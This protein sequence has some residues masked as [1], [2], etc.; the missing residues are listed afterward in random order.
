M[1]EQR[2]L[3]PRVPGSSPG[4][5]IFF[6]AMHKR[7]KFFP[8]VI[9]FLLLSVHSSLLSQIR[10]KTKLLYFIPS[11][12]TFREIYGPGLMG[13]G[14]IEAGLVKNI[15]IWLE[16]NYLKKTGKLSITNEKTSLQIIP[17]LLGI[18]YN[19]IFNKI[20]HPYIGLG[21]GCFFYNEANPI[22]KVEK[23]NFAWIA[24]TGAIIYLNRLFFIDTLLEYSSC[25]VNPA[26]IEVNLGGLMMGVS[27]G[28]V[29]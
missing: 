8:V 13:G 27:F 18:K 17:I 22:G 24:K 2:T 4:R 7:K 19:F 29:F 28:V 5:V 12:E 23:N 20:I 6:N 21:G 10:L 1:A 11:E 16:F 14:E 26:G 15:N 3:N 9:I 25:H